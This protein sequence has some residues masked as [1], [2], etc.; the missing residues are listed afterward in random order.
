LPIDTPNQSPIDSPKQKSQEHSRCKR[1]GYMIC[2]NIGFKICDHK[3]WV[4]F[5][6][7][8]GTKCKQVGNY[9]RCE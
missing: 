2:D 3:K 1:D 7:G 5:D 6:C 4:K 9:I 8:E